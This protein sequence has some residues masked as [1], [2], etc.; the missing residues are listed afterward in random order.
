MDDVLKLPRIQGKPLEVIVSPH[1]KANSY[2]RGKPE[3]EEHVLDIVDAIVQ[4]KPLPHWAYRSGIDS[5]DPPDS[6]LARYGIMHLH[7]GSKASSELLFLMQFQHHVVILA[8][9]NHKHF[10]EDPP[11]SLLHQFH[12]RKVIELNALREEQ[13]VADEA[14]AAR[15]A[16]DRKRARAAA[17][18][19]GIFPRKKD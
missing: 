12:Q 10:A 17:I 2:Y 9:G 1:F 8:I 3:L 5:N 7:L 13:R 6:V 4:G 11:G 19:S 15:E 18:K 16:G 14:A